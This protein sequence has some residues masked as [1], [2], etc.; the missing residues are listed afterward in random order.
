MHILYSI[1]C[2]LLDLN[3]YIILF[4]LRIIVCVTKLSRAVI[5][6]INEPAKIYKY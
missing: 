4:K 2:L 3:T 1:F 6:N 5:F